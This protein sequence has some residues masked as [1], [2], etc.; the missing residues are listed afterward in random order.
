MTPIRAL[1]HR[2]VLAL[3]AGIALVFSVHAQT[4]PDRLRV[5]IL[6]L[7]DVYQTLPMDNGKSG[8]L[9]RVATL[10]KKIMAESPNTL[11]LL[12]GDTISPSVASSVFKGEQMIAAW[13]A[14]GLDYSVLGNHEFDFGPDVLL[15]R[16]KES[17]FVWL[18]SNVIDRRT[19][20]PFGGMP[21]YVIRDFGGVRVGLFGLLTPDTATSSKPGPDVRFVNPVLAAK[22]IVKK[23]RKGGA[24]IIIAITHLAMSEDKYLAQRVPQIDVIIGGHEHELLQSHAGRTPIFKWGQDARTLGRIDLNISTATRKVESIDWAGIPIT[25]ALADDQA[26]AAVA[27]EYEKKLDAAL[28]QPVGQTSVELDARSIT[29][30]SR[31]TNL[32]NLVTDAFRQT[33]GADVALLNGGSIRANTTLAPGPVTKRDTIAI[34][35][36]GNPVVKIE[37]SG[38]ALRAALENGVSRIV[39]EEESGRFP[40]VSG[41]SFT[42]DARKPAGSRVTEVTIN[43]QPLD[44]K[45]NYSLALTP[46]LANGGDGYSMFTGARLLV[47]VESAQ[48]DST[49][50]ANAIT[51]AG[52]VSPKV[53][54]RSKRLDATAAER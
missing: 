29:S 15:A 5:T 40:Q 49:I 44:G 48:L 19:N 31:E 47:D 45:K 36:F 20:K 6:Q 32:G 2:A 7:N 3:V 35:P 46:Y 42:F 41:L 28:G 30:R 54:G 24:Q 38:T 18:G 22:D 27:A 52:T 11:F 43:G 14:M 34:L 26:V 50:L 33:L 17:K 12:A 9:A 8:G 25:N 23:L 39:E 21:S 10:R 51:A 16:M 13:N 1:P 37:V 53:E 4:Q